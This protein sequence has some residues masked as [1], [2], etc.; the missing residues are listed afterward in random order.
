MI[1]AETLRVPGYEGK[2]IVLPLL[3]VVDIDVN[4]VVGPI[5]CFFVSLKF[6]TSSIWMSSIMMSSVLVVVPSLVLVLKTRL[7]FLVQLQLH[8]DL[9]HHGLE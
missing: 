5:R 3:I 9:L 6:S 4:V 8:G 1:V 7:V 2:E